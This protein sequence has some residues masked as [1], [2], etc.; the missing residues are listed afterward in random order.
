[1]KVYF[2][3]DDVLHIVP[4]SGIEAMAIKYWMAEYNKHGTR[5]LEIV[6]ETPKAPM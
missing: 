4:E 6:T 5:M 3:G 2:S 1:M